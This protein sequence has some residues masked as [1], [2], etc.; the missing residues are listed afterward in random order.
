MRGFTA[1]EVAERYGQHTAET[2]Q[3]FSQN[4]LAR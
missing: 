2:G 3:R 4:A 1:D